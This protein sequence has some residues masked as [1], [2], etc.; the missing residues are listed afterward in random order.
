[1]QGPKISS[2]GKLMYQDRT[3]MSTFRDG[4]GPGLKLSNGREETCA[5]LIVGLARSL[6]EPVPEDGVEYLVTRL[7]TAR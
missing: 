4:Q 2:K 6:Q 1:M 5:A 3:Q 7:Y